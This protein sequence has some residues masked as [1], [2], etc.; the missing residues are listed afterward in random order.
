MESDW[1][2]DGLGWPVGIQYIFFNCNLILFKK[3][4]K[5][6]KKQWVRLE[7]VGNWVSVVVFF[8][9]FWG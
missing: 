3:N 7:Q 5:K 2:L 8:L 6:K 9:L 1:P 4:V